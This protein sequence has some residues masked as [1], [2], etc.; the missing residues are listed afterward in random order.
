M[1][2]DFREGGY[3]IKT[4]GGLT[5]G[6]FTKDRLYGGKRLDQEF[7]VGTLA[8]PDG[9]EVF[10]LLDAEVL[11]EPVPTDIGEAT[12]TVLRVR[13]LDPSTN[14]PAGDV[15]DVGTLSQAVAGKAREK[16]DG[17]LPA[18]V[19][20][21]YVEAGT[22]GYSD[23]LVLSFVAEWDGPALDFQ[24]L[25]GAVTTEKAKARK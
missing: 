25:A 10:I 24:P 18:L 20:A 2:E 22:E 21:H 11:A 13:K 17:D 3:I 7:E 15:F 9:G 16:E 6:M 12:K 14:L 1:L 4:L 19:R 8:N 5:M 23:A